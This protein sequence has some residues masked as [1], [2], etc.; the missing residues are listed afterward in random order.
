MGATDHLL[1][2]AAKAM[3]LF[4]ERWTLLVVRELVLGSKRFNELRRQLPEVSPSVLS[5]RLHRLA[6]T[7]IVRKSMVDGDVHYVLTE[8]GRDLRPVVEALGA[9]G[10]RWLEST[11]DASARS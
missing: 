6:I 5:K 2:P 8:A 1:C 10:A 11:D 9:W 3:E 7:G 4:D